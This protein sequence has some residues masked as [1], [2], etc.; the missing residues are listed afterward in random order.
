MLENSVRGKNVRRKTQRHLQLVAGG[1]TTTIFRVQWS[2]I[3]SLIKK[4]NKMPFPS[5]ALN[6]FLLG[7][8]FLLY[9]NESIPISSSLLRP[10]PLPLD[11]LPDQRQRRQRSRQHLRKKKPN[12]KTH[13][14][15]DILAGYHVNGVGYCEKGKGRRRK[16][17][18]GIWATTSR[19]WL[20][21]CWGFELLSL[22]VRGVQNLG[23]ECYWLQDVP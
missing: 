4:S 19:V 5:A 1:T 14:L 18:G 22:S 12:S 7:P 9:P 10:L 15:L 16:V 3:P 23:G 11:H 13:P 2:A 21:G 8:F 6:N 17:E 20:S